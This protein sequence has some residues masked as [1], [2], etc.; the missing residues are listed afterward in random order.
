MQHGHDT[1]NTTP[2]PTDVSPETPET[3][4]SELITNWPARCGLEDVAVLECLLDDA[5]KHLYN[6]LK[7]LPV[8]A[9][10]AIREARVFLAQF[11]QP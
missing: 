4:A 6:A 7:L 11:R 10:D 5:L 2:T 8:P 1:S 9:N 3:S